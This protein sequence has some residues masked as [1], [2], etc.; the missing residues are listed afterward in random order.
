MNAIAE[1]NLRKAPVNQENQVRELDQ[2]DLDMVAG[3]ASTTTC[4]NFYRLNGN[5]KKT[6]C[7]TTTTD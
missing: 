4:T 6:V 1:K 3:G 7:T 5:L 2:N